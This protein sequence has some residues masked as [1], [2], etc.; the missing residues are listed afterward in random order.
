MTSSRLPTLSPPLLV[1]GPLLP[2]PTLKSHF[3]ALTPPVFDGLKPG[4]TTRSALPM[5]PLRLPQLRAHRLSA[6]QSSQPDKRF[7]YH[8]QKAKWPTTEDTLFF[9]KPAYRVGGSVQGS[10]KR[11]REMGAETWTYLEPPPG[12]CCWARVERVRWATPHAEHRRRGNL[13]QGWSPRP[14]SHWEPAGEPAPTPHHRRFVALCKDTQEGR[15][16]GGRD[17]FLEEI[18]DTELDLQGSWA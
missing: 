14:S 9:T 5:R 2:L 13:R 15:R 8:A 4:G 17:I 18:I 7:L 6:A 1:Q 3:I 12:H 11:S 16:Q 10:A